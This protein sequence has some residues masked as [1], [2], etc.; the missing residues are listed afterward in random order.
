M[1]NFLKNKSVVFAISLILGGLVAILLAFAL[2]YIIAI[3]I[4]DFH[5]SWMIIN[6]LISAV[7]LITIFAIASKKIH[8]YLVKFLDNK[9]E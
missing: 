9:I 6:L 5:S 4:G 1:R 2:F 8:K 7:L 3:L